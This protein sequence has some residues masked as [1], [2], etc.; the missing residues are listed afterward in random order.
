MKTLVETLIEG[1][2]LTEEQQRTALAGKSALPEV[3]ALLSMVE[4]AIG[5]ARDESEIPGGGVVRDEACGAARH[6]RVLR[7]DMLA[8]LKSQQ[9]EQSNE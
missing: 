5:K 2:A 1:G 8:M 4:F 6:L 9:R 3:K 7:D